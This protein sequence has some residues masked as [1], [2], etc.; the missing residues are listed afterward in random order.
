MIIILIMARILYLT[1]YYHN[2]HEA[3]GLRA[4][5]YTAALAD[6]GISV[7]VITSGEKSETENVDSNVTVHSISSE[8]IKRSRYLKLRMDPNSPYKQFGLLYFRPPGPDA[9][10]GLN[11]TFHV[12]ADGVGEDIQADAIVP[13]SVCWRLAK[14]SQA[15]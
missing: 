7:H 10:S 13:L 9:D 2:P 4:Q 11:F 8:E 6:A 3:A 1:Q 14:T 12:C 5:R 15:D